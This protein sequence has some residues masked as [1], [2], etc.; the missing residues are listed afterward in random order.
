MVVDFHT[1]V[2]PDKIA[3][4]TIDYLAEKGGNTPFSDGTVSGLYSALEKG[5]VDVAVALPVLTK[6]E[7]FESVLNFVTKINE[8]L[9]SKEK[10]IISF[11]GIHPACE[12][13]K[14]KLKRVKDAGLKGVKIHP[15]YQN[16]FIDDD[17]YIEI[18]KCAKDL[19][20]IV[21]THAGID[22]GYRECTVKS[23]PELTRKVIDKVGHEKFVLAHLG[24]SEMVEDVLKYL[25]GQK[26]YFDT[27]FVLN[28]IKKEEFLSV[29]DK[30]G[31]DRILFASDFPWS[32]FDRDVEILKSFV[33]DSDTRD[34]ILY[35]NALSLL[36]L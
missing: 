19:D 12:D 23:P 10:K 25:A 18:L 6:P 17:G 29:L 33:N 22:C 27:A 28:R 4:K 9:S 34:K 26:V 13:I 36:G 5:L 32:S 24:G 11:G 7:Q 35:K 3:K 2:F 14:G 31:E 21:V 20:L 16:T 30:H 8:E 1:H 15:D